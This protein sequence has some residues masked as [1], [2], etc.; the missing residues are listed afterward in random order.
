M[1]AVHVQAMVA[2]LKLPL[3]AGAV[4]PLPDIYRVQGII[5]AALAA[6]ESLMFKAGNNSQL[7]QMSMKAFRE[8]SVLTV[9]QFTEEIDVH[10]RCAPRLLLCAA[11]KAADVLRPHTAPPRPRLVAA[12]R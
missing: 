1:R 3:E 12:A 10:L 8:L 11:V 9:G 4:P 7:V 2:R 6:E 5:D